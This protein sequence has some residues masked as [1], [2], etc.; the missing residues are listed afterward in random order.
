MIIIWRIV[1]SLL[2]VR[3]TS[4]Y[5]VELER[6]KREFCEKNIC[7]DGYFTVLTGNVRFL[8]QKFL[9]FSKKKLD[10]FIML[11]YQTL[12]LVA[13]NPN[14]GKFPSVTV[15]FAKSLP[16]KVALNQWP[17]GCSAICY[18]DF[19]FCSIWLVAF[20]PG[21]QVSLRVFQHVGQACDTRK[22][23]CIVVLFVQSWVLSMVPYHQLN[24]QS[25]LH[26][27]T[28]PLWFL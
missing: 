13:G 5:I 2:Q 9:L 12:N 8:P 25:F 27:Y 3:I 23:G 6:T 16:W 20:R 15:S 4:K 24:H 26:R 11:W 21:R 22:K 14:L 28:S 10:F 7:C 17:D 1:K 18:P 19:Q